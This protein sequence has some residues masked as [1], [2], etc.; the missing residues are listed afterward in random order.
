MKWNDKLEQKVASMHNDGYSSVAI[1]MITG[2]TRNQVISK[3]GRMTSCSNR[4]SGI[5]V[6]QVKK[7]IQ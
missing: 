4:K 5:T 1:S 2:L 3:L 7:L 6:W